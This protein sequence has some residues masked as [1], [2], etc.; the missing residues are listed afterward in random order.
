MKHAD[1]YF[2][3][4]VN[5]LLFLLSAA[6]GFI[7]ALPFSSCSLEPVS[8]PPYVIG[9]PVCVIG[10]KT[11]CYLAAGIEFD[12]YN[13][14]SRDISSFSVSAMVYDRD[15]GENPFIGSN[16]VTADF[17][18]LLSGNSKA[19]FAVSLD[20]YMYAV[21]AS[22]YVIDFFYVTRIE[23]ADGSSWTDENGIYH[24]GSE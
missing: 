18:G 2:S 14:D 17:S 24:T 8:A 3:N 12:F 20:P 13:I 4:P 23:Y 11:D 10:E 19:S 22:P 21:P 15:T 1:S 5:A 16:R 6:A 9:K 7:A